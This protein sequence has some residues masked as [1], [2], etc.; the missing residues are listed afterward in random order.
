MGTKGKKKEEERVDVQILRGKDHFT[1]TGS[2]CDGS[3]PSNRASFFSG[4]AF[5]ATYFTEEE[6]GF[7]SG[8]YSTGCLGAESDLRGMHDLNA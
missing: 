6:E 8:T 2:A 3:L 5:S 7:H 1:G 4:R